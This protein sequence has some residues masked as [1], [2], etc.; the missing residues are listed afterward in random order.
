[1]GGGHIAGCLVDHPVLGCQGGWSGFKA[2]FLHLGPLG[3]QTEHGSEPP[4]EADNLPQ[5]P[6]SGKVSGK[7]DRVSTFRGKRPDWP[8]FASL[9]RM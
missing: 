8:A 6:V 7:L 5:P 4:G 1:M 9:R 3:G 2:K